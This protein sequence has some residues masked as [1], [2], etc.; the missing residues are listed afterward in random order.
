MRKRI[1]SSEIPIKLNALITGYTVA[2]TRY[3]FFYGV[4]H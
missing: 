2:Q 4:L 1:D 3:I